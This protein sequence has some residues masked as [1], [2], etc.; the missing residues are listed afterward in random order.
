MSEHD[1]ERFWEPSRRSELDTEVVTCKR[2]GLTVE[3]PTDIVGDPIEGP[4]D[5]EALTPDWLSAH[6]LAQ[7]C[8]E[9]DVREVHAR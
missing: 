1:W 8:E 5:M 2:C 4:P 6:G 3:N 9:H 7:T